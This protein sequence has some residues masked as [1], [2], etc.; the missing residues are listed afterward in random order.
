MGVYKLWGCL[1]SWGGN[2]R[3]YVL[4]ILGYVLSRGLACSY[5]T[6]VDN[7]LTIRGEYQCKLATLE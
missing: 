1:Y 5:I 6:G 2:K 4:L 3:M 7:L